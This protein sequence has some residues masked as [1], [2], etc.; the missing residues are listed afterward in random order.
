MVPKHSYKMLKTKNR[1]YH[2]C[3]FESVIHMYQTTIVLVVKKI[4][5]KQFK[6]T[7]NTYLLQTWLSIDTARTQ[8]ISLKA[9]ITLSN[10][11]RD[12]VESSLCTG[13]RHTTSLNFEYVDWTINVCTV[14]TG[15]P[16][17]FRPTKVPLEYS[18]RLAVYTSSIMRVTIF[19]FSS[20]FSVLCLR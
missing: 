1:L 19:S 9:A 11:Y 3:N 8:K 4:I 20:K 14:L 15:S 5:K 6:H 12:W 17:L 2:K 18:I 10:R 7:L 16:S 13:T